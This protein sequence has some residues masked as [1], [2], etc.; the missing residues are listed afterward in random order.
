M[1]GLDCANWE[2]ENDATLATYNHP[3]TITLA[4]GEYVVRTLESLF[5]FIL[6]YF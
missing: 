3:N 1:S 6:F 4:F 2:S 5:Y